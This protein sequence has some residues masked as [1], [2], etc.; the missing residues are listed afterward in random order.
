MVLI[1]CTVVL[2]GQQFK[3]VA[4][5]LTTGVM[6]VSVFVCAACVCVGVCM[7]A[8][9]CRTPASTGQTPPPPSKKT[10]HMCAL[11]DPE[12]IHHMQ[13]HTRSRTHTHLQIYSW[14]V[15]HNLFLVTKYNCHINVEV[16]SSIKAVKYLYKYVYKGPDRC[17]VEIGKPV[18]EIKKYMDAR[19]V[20]APE[21][22]W[23]IFGFDLYDNKPAVY[24][25]A[26]HTPDQQSVVFDETD[27]PNDVAG[28]AENQSTLL[29]YFKAMEANR[30]KRHL[31]Y[32]DM[33]KEFVYHKSGKEKG[34]WTE[35]RRNQTFPTVGRIYQISPNQGEVYYIRL[36]LLHRAGVTS[37]RGNLFAPLMVLFV[38]RLRT[39]VGGWVSSMT[40]VTILLRLRRLASLQPRHP[41][42]NF[43]LL[44]LLLGAGTLW[45]FGID[46]SVI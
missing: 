14:V 11:T 39:R 38:K 4:R 16:V 36:L 32:Q 44:F 12:H 27:D 45:T 43:S 21:A 28:R 33:H 40:T 2:K 23:R 17:T 7:H 18:D 25:L 31:K 26:V 22:A 19:Y 20:A 35:R 3:S 15:P 42:V 46:L 9:T 41:S 5:H 6:C 29:G 8:T 1:L 34:T 30:E 24:R 37:I 10:L 13:T